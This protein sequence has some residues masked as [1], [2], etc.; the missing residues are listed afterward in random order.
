MMANKKCHHSNTR[1]DIQCDD[2]IS[3]LSVPLV[4]VALVPVLPVSSVSFF[5]N[6]EPNRFLP[7]I[8]P[9]GSIKKFCGIACTPY[10]VETSFFQNFKSDTCV[11][12]KP[13]FSIAASHLYA[14]ACCCIRYPVPVSWPN[15][16]KVSLRGR[17]L[18]VCKRSFP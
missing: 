17:A 9:L 3:Y 5:T 6:A 2:F 11:Q 16:I 1:D 15:P 10:K 18:A 4:L 12:T 14:D 13:S 8:F 7:T